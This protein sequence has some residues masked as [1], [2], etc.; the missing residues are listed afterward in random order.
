[1]DLLLFIML[2][3]VASLCYL[4]PTFVAVVN[5]H[6]YALPIFIANLFFGVTVVGWAALL[7]FAILKEFRA[8][9][10]V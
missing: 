5:K 8:E 4:I 3:I 6:K 9:N 7:I 2:L 1:M 10:K